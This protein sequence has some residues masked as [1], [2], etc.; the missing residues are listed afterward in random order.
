MSLC[1]RVLYSRHLTQKR[2]TYHDGFVKLQ[3]S[4]TA[5]LFSEDGVEL[6]TTTIPPSTTLTESTE[7]FRRFEGFVV[8][9]EEECQIEDLP[10]NKGKNILFLDQNVL[11]LGQTFLFLYSK[12]PVIVSEFPVFR[13]SRKDKNRTSKMEQAPHW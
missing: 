3:S 6:S 1:F 7:D 4:R 10:K 12:C 11:L 5:V 2:R 13:T 8:D 9:F